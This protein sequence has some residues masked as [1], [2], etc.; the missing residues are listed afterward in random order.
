MERGR[1]INLQ[2]RHKTKTTW[3]DL[4]GHF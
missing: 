3:L 2:G 1:R 4:K